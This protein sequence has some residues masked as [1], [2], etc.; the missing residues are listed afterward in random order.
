MD[1]QDLEPDADCFRPGDVWQNSRGHQYRVVRIA[2]G[3]ARLV[4]LRTGDSL[5]RL[6]DQIGAHTG[7]PWVRVSCGA[8]KGL[9]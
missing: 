8:S 5:T 1:E 3:V 6:W 2:G 9:T 4:S 7:T